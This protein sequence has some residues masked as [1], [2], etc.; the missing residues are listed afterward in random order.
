M[1]IPLLEL[2]SDNVQDQVSVKC[3]GLRNCTPQLHDYLPVSKY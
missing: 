2:S 3:S 1:N